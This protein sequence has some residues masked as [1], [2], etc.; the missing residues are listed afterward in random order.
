MKVERFEL[1]PVCVPFR[2]PFAHARIARRETRAVIVVLHSDAGVAGFGEILPREYVTGETIEGVLSDFGP[3]IGARFTGLSFS[4]VEDV[5]E[6]LGR[7][8]DRAGRSLA[9]FCGFETALIDL[10][11]RTFG[12]ALGDTLGG[13][14]GPPLPAGTVIG[15]DVTTKALPRRAAI[16]RLCGAKHVKVKVGL[17]D[18]P[19]R[20]S[21]IADAVGVPLRI[22]ANGVWVSAEE[23]VRRLRMMRGIPLASIEQPLPPHDIAGA[24]RIRE[25]IGIP[26]VADEALCTRQ[27]ADRLI[28]GRAAD[29]FNIRIAKC[30]GVL[31]AS[32]IL[33]RARECGLGCHLGALVGETGILTRVTEMFSRFVSGFE[34]LEG[35][36]QNVSLLA[37]DILE[38]P[39]EAVHASA[40]AMGL[41][42]RVSME[43]IFQAASYG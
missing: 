13:Q 37:R 12:F 9:T 33:T 7:E 20:L 32:R 39:R 11:G 16:M 41:G 5:V 6:Y 14:P 30:G 3:A 17:P 34:F 4:D 26:V 42:V 23:A 19:E 40:F 25:E 24:R 15:F 31:G 28:E 2:G 43:R 35:K 29:I 1:H 27:D 36:G 8:L 18:D 38:D 21:I 10:A 22:D